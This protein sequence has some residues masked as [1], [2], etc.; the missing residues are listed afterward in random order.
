MDR[1]HKR[2]S[3]E[4]I[5]VLL[6]GYC[7]GTIERVS[8][9]E[10]LGIGKTRFFA[11]LKEYRQNPKA[12]PLPTSEGHRPS[13]LPLWKQRLRGNCCGRKSWSRTTDCLSPATTTLPSHRRSDYRHE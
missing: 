5:K 12:F 2:F 10:T 8:V 11:L 4:Q 7:Q 1:I 9:E 3:A 6:Q 13:C